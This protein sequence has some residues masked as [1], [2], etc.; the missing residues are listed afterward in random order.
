MNVQETHA[1]VDGKAYAIWRYIVGWAC[2]HLAVDEYED[3]QMK[4]IFMHK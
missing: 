4:E 3:D 1:N 2:T